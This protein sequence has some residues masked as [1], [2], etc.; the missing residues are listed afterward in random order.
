MS[1]CDN[2]KQEYID[3]STH[4]RYCDKYF[5]F[6]NEV[7]ELYKNDNL[8]IREIAILLKLSIG[9][10]RQ[11]L[12]GITRNG[13]DAAKL[14][15]IKYT[16]IF[17]EETKILL[18]EIRLK[19]LKENPEKTAWRQKNMSY[20]EKKFLEKIITLEWDK[21]FLIKRE[22]SIYP[23]FIDFAFENEKVAVEIDGSQHLL[24]DR[25]ESDVKKD[26]LLSDN[27]W[28]IIRITAKEINENLDNVLLELEKFL[29]SDIKYEKIGI[30]KE[31]KIYIKKDRSENRFTQLE[32]NSQK[33][34]R[35]VL[36]PSH[37]QLTQDVENI[38]YSATGRKYGVSDNCI[39]K[40]IKMYEKYGDE[41]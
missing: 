6:K 32:K 23:Y 13:S 26:K 25:I 33:K 39:R 2:C 19:W 35:K 18:R 36:R 28:R 20:P 37:E 17:K 27:G 31:K 4:K 22:K 5:H 8:S 9:R 15:K 1:I 34:Q 40:W 38:G 30:L 24:P 29:Y 41:F 12:K 10:V 7:I 3:I 14:A 11:F 21:K 16:L